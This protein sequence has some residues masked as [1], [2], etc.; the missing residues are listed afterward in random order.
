MSKI[1]IP[2]MS[3]EEKIAFVKE[4]YK[5]TI[6]T[7]VKLKRADISPE[8][9]TKIL[10]EANEELQAQTNQIIKGSQDEY[11]KYPLYPLLQNSR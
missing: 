10:I 7:F 9:L 1:V 5:A 6:R 2:Q 11:E 4:A 3:K 8:E